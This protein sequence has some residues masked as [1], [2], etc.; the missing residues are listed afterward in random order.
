[1]GF[2]RWVGQ[3]TAS[4]IEASGGGTLTP[5]GEVAAGS[6]MALAESLLLQRF[7]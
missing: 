6:N 2:N 5:A 3:N 1:M 7:N 4:R